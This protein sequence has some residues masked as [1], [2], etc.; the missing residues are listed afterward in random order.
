MKILDLGCGKKK[1]PGSIGLD[2]SDKTDADIIHD[3][4]VFPYPLED[5][6][7]DY[8]NV[9]N[10]IEHVDNVI[11][12]MEEIHRVTKNSATIKII[13]PYFRSEYAFI[14]PT[15][16]HFFT[17]R[18]FYYFDPSHKF[19]ELYKYSDVHFKVNNIIFDEQIPHNLFG[20]IITKIAN[21]KKL[22]SLYEHWFSHI[23]PLNTLT[24]YLETVK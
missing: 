9:D 17:T 11:R 8:V 3:L 7:F 6:Q 24:Y 5:N 14:D 15:H 21:N 10:V 16:K 23:Y 13:V 2:I 4:N 19:N 1:Y 18:S 22:M 20:K 12:V